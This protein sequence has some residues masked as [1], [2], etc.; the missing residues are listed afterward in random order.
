MDRSW[1]VYAFP[2]AAFG[3][4]S[5]VLPGITIRAQTGSAARQAAGPQMVPTRSPLPSAHILDLQGLV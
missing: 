1:L 3:S 5:A 4:F 2:Q